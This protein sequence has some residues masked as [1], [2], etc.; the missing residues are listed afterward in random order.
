M[1]LP[2]GAKLTGKSGNGICFFWKLRQYFIAKPSASGVYPV[3]FAQFIKTLAPGSKIR[4]VGLTGPMR[5]VKMMRP[6]A[7]QL[8]P[9]CRSHGRDFLKG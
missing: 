4:H 1:K 9:V 7:S 2:H 5:F 3:G 6:S 8:T